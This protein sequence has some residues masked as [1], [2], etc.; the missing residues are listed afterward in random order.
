MNALP[1]SPSAPDGF[2]LAADGF[3]YKFF[4]DSKLATNSEA[5]AICES[6]GATLPVILDRQ[7]NK[8]V[9][10]FYAK[11]GGHIG[12]HDN[13]EGIFETAY[14]EANGFNLMTCQLA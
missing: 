10:G 11:L 7:S 3:H 9:N 2:V 5:E 4:G 12:I 6:F 1:G 8:I 13:G 14:G